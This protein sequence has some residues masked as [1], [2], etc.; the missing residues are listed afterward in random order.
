MLLIP[1]CDTCLGGS[2]ILF[3]LLMSGALSD[4]IS[5][6]NVL[7]KLLAKFDWYSYVLSQV[8]KIEDAG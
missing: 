2:Y 7:Q 8:G 3:N 5:V 6:H 1:T 4:A